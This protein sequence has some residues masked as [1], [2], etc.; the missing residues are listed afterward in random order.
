MTGADTFGALLRRRTFIP[1]N[2]GDVLGRDGERK[3][4]SVCAVD[5]R[6]GVGVRA[7]RELGGDPAIKGLS[8]ELSLFR[9]VGVVGTALE[10]SP[11]A[12]LTC[13]RIVNS[14]LGDR[15]PGEAASDRC[16][17]LREGENKMFLVRW[18]FGVVEVDPE[19]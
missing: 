14:E 11:F 13:S 6:F 17:E 8:D 16:L 5:I 15:N 9:C 18:D 12:T 7:R 1:P 4:S 2:K 10:D 3:T 19:A